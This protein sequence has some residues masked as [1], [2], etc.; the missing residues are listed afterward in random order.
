MFPSHHFLCYISKNDHHVVLGFDEWSGPTSVLSAC[1]EKANVCGFARNF[2]NIGWMRRSFVGIALAITLFAAV[3]RGQAPPAAERALQQ[4]NRLRQLQQFEQDTRM[5]ANP[6]IPPGERLLLDFGGYFSFDYLSIDDSNH[7]NHGLRQ[8]ELVGYLRANLDGAQEVFVRGRTD[9]RDFNP[10]DSFDGFGSRLIDPDLDRGYYRFD[11]QRAQAAYGK[12]P[13]P[14]KVVAEVGRDLAYWANGLVLT[15]V[16]DGGLITVGAG[17]VELTGLVGITPTRTVDIDTSRPEFN[18]NTRRLFYGA[19]LS[20]QAGEHRPFI[21]FLEQNDQNNK[22]V[23]VVGPLTTAFDYNSYYIG[24]GSQGAVIDKLRYE[25]EAVYEG[26]STLSNS[27]STAGTGSLVPVKQTRNDIQAWAADGRLDYLTEGPHQTRFSGEAII[28]SGD[29]NRGTS[30]NTFNGS[31]PGTLDH[32][33][34]GFGLLNTGLAFSPEVSNLLVGRIGASTFPLPEHAVFK[35]MQ[36][37]VDV[38]AF[39]KLLRDAPIDEPTGAHR[40]L[41]CEP[42]LY[43]NWQIASD[44]TL[45]LRYGIFIPDHSAFGHGSAGDVRQFFFGGLTFSF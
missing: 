8:Y 1:Y 13:G 21:Y 4:E 45:A 23:S 34:N 9:Y 11:L 35:R 26:G 31:K 39:G 41:G 3:A 7:N 37:G 33:F 12:G 44:V 38:F 32:G 36:V 24:T 10:G 16:L 15:E 43:V 2:R 18:Q 19:M 14:I 22:D 42:D 29:H 6:D 30:S 28:A 5:Q 25:V 17:P 20:A 40:Y 27:F